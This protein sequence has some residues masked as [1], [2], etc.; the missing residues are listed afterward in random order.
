MM[1]NHIKLH[2][3]LLGPPAVGKLTISR[4]LSTM[5]EYPIYDNSLSINTALLLYKYGSK[6]QTFKANHQLL[7]RIR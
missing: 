7:F 3:F 2:Y 6:E 5:T 1:K 4:I